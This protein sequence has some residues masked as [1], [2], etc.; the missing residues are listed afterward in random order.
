MFGA[1]V[2]FTVFFV[3]MKHAVQLLSLWTQGKLKNRIG[4]ENSIGTVQIN[5]NNEVESTALS[6]FTTCASAGTTSFIHFTPPHLRSFEENC[7]WERRLR[8]FKVTNVAPGD[9][10][11]AA[12]VSDTSPSLLA[13]SYRSLQLICLRNII[14]ELPNAA[15]RSYFINQLQLG[16]GAASFQ[17]D[18]SSAMPG[19]N[20]GALLQ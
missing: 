20:N 12:F 4:S 14:M 1:L 8:L 7:T 10:L 13:T 3:L 19:E 9:A 11:M 16:S 18:S 17:D 6:H 5:L 15:P 2:T